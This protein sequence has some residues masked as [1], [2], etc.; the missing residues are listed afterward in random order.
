MRICTWVLLYL[1]MSRLVNVPGRLIFF[2][3]RQGGMDLGQKEGGGEMR[4]M[5]REK[6]LVRVCI[7]KKR[8]HIFTKKKII[9]DPIYPTLSSDCI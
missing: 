8:K 9:C 6:V 4:E 1:V 2:G 7:R 5:K 3:G